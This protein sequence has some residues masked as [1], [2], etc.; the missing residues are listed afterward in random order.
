MIKKGLPILILLFIVLTSCTQQKQL[1]YLKDVA[2]DSTTTLIPN[3]N[4]PEYRIQQRDILYIKIM[5]LNEEMNNILNVGSSSSSSQLYQSET[6]LF[7]NGYT[8]DD[9]GSVEI[10]ILGKIKV[11]NS[12]IV[13]AQQA[14]SEKADVYLK[15]ANVFL[16][17]M[18]FKYTILGEVNKPGTY[19]NYNNQLTI[20]EAIG[21]SGDITPYGN[22]KKILILRP[23]QNGTK[24]Y[25]VNLTDKDLLSSKSYYLLP[26]DI[27]YVEPI[28]SKIFQINMPS[29]GLLLSSIT[30]LILVLNYINIH[31]V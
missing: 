13:E 23:T 1:I 28:K 17:L 21:K 18:S 30:T 16:K 10:P 11:L 25:K 8:V 27:I 14:I 3:N 2:S 31:K 15:D 4:I 29:L 20:L 12:T 9:S 7:I 19:N 5:T 22:R 26:N 6:N 24:V